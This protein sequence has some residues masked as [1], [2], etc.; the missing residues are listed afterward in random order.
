[1]VGASYHGKAEIEVLGVSHSAAR[2]ECGV[3]SI[4]STGPWKGSIVFTIQVLVRDQQND[5]V[6]GSSVCEASARLWTMMYFSITHPFCQ[7]S[8]FLSVAKVESRLA[9]R[10]NQIAA[11]DDPLADTKS[12]LS[13]IDL[14]LSMLDTIS[15]IASVTDNTAEAEFEGHDDRR[16][17]LRQCL[18]E[19]HR[20][21]P[22]RVND[23]KGG[24]SGVLL[25]CYK[26][27]CV[28]LAA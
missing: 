25:M 19:Q 6:Q 23:C 17:D 18:R 2:Q 1:V 8:W 14:S 15:C 27:C 21:Q 10:V 22:S 24:I 5:R 4:R 9:D 3:E 16:W 11:P 7:K 13:P 12:L 28:E 26:V 20:A